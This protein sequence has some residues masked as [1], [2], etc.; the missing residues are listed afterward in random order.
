MSRVRIFA[1]KTSLLSF[2]LALL[3]IL[4]PSITH[5]ASAAAVTAVARSGFG[6][7]ANQSV[8]DQSVGNATN[9]IAYRLSGGDC[10]IEFKNVGTTTWNVSNG[11]SLVRYLIVGGGG[12]GTRGICSIYWGQ[13]G[14]GGE[15]LAGTLGVVQGSIET[16]VVGAGGSRTGNCT[17]SASPGNA[18]T[19]SS[20]KGLT[21]R[22]G[23]PGNNTTVDN[24]GRNGGTSGSG[25]SGGVGTATGATGCASPSLCGTGGGGGAGGVGNVKDGGPGVVDTITGSSLGYGGGGGGR[26]N[27]GSGAV[28]VDHG[29]AATGDATANRGGGGADAADA[30][31]GGAG[32][33]GTVIVRYTPDTTAPSTSISIAANYLTS[34]TSVSTVLTTNET[35]SS[36]TLY[37]STSSSLTS[38]T[39]CGTTSNPTNGQ[40]LTCTIAASD[41]TYYIYSGGTDSA[42]NVE[43]APGSADDSIIRDT[44]AP[45]VTGVTSTATNGSKGVGSTPPILV[46]FSETVTVSTSGGTP[47]ILMETGST[48]RAATY[49]TGTGTTRLNFTYTVVSGDIS[50][51]LDYTSTSAL[52]PNGGTITDAAGNAAVLTLPEP[53]ASGSLSNAKNIVIDTVHPTFVS[54]TLLAI[55]NQIRIV[56]S[57]TV[58]TTA[59]NNLPA[60]TSFRIN[61][62]GTTRLATAISKTDTSEVT[63]T[64]PVSIKVG[65]TITLAYLDPTES[66]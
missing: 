63:I 18:G 59:P 26:D 9:V 29:G 30:S 20:F 4:T 51:D 39:S 25:K 37:Y 42:G 24:A 34:G 56:F 40:T 36:V 21:A 11:I 16:I 66:D 12:S 1:T 3:P 47:T 33:S 54:A 14:G 52:Q 13:G 60:A 19:S 65:Q 53:G 38:P 28:T 46:D 17:S 27:V 44:V 31:F 50:P 15:V 6:D 2:V 61:D 57:E 10:V 43:S 7:H 35:L 55:G 49:T 22:P 48:D 58:S 23:N 62:S 32:G 8:C 45:T 64:I 41:G 5:S